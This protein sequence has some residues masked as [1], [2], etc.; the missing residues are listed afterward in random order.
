MKMF[1]TTA[2]LAFGLTNACDEFS[3]IVDGVCADD[4]LDSMIGICPQALVVKTGG[5]SAGDCKSQGYTVANGTTTQKAGPCGTL[6]FN[7][8]TKPALV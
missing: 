2:V 3:K 1:A 6:T 5:L 7:E 8:Y 4:C